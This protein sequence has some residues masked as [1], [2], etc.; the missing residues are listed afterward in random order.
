MTTTTFDPTE[1][2]SADEKTRDAENL[3]IGEQL[4]TMEAEDTAR[5]YQQIDAE[6]GLIDGKFKSQEDLLKAY[7][8]LERKLSQGEPVEEEA[9][10]SEPTSDTTEEEQVEEQ[11]QQ[12]ETL[13]RTALTRASE[14]FANG[15][16]SE[17]TIEA[18]A[19]MDSKELIKTYIEQYAQSQ[20]QVQQSTIQESE[21]KAIKEIAGGDEGYATMLTWASKNLEA[22]EIDAFNGVANSGNTAALRFAVEALSARYKAKEGYEA[23]LVSGKSAASSKEVF[24]SHAELAR[25]ISDPRYHNDP[26]YRGDVEKKLAASKDLL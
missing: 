4:S 5:K 25:A 20:Q 3:Q 12:E 7:K 17:E 8:E 18:L 2:P 21:V 13:T 23:P 22:A 14:E 11:E 15:E 26:A 10:P 16:V 19:Q 9:T 1:G 6:N 24:R